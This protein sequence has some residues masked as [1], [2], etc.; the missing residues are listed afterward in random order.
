MMTLAGLIKHMAFVEDGFTAKAQG[1][2]VGPPWNVRDW[3]ANDG[4]GWE[5]ALTDEAEALYSLW[6]G[7]VTRSRA[8]WAGLVENR[9]LDVAPPVGDDYVVNRRRV[10]TDLLEENL[11]HT[12]HA[13]LLREAVDGLSGNGAP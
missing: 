10:L 1:Q 2:P 12:G 4:W 11:I 5:S 7:A 3:V 13:S 8:A 9:G 6:Y